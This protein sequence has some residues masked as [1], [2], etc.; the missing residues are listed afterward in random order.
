MQRPDNPHVALILGKLVA[1]GEG[2]PTNEQKCQLLADLHARAP[3]AVQMVHME[4]LRRSDRMG[5]GL[6]EAKTCIGQ[7][8][9]KIEELLGKAWYPGLFMGYLGEPAERC[10][11]VFQGNTW[12]VVGVFD[13]VPVDSLTKGCEVLLNRELTAIVGLSPRPCRPT[14]QIATV[15]E[16]TA[17]GNLII[18]SQE[19][20]VEVEM[21]ASLKDVPIKAGDRVRWDSSA[22]I[23]FERVEGSD[24]SQYLLGEVPNVPLDAVGGQEENMAKLL[25]V[26]S[27]VLVEPQKAA[28]YGLSGRSSVLLVGKPGCGKTLMVRT[29]VSEIARRAGR[30]A[31]FFAVKPSEWESCLVG[32]TEK[33]I[34]ALFT[35][36]RTST[37]DGSLAVLFLDEVD[38]VGRVRG[39]AQGHYSDK[40]LNALLAELD[41]FTG[42]EGVAVVATTN[43]KDLIDSALLQRLSDHELHVRP[44]DMK[45]AKAIFSIHLRPSL[46]FSPNGTMASATRLELIETAVARIYNPNS[47]YTELCRLKFRD[48]KTRM[49]SA[50]DFACGRLFEQICKAAKLSAYQREVRGGQRGLA[51]GDIEEAV[52]SAMERLATNVTIH[53]VRNQLPDLPTDVDVV[54]VEPIP[55]RVDRPHRY[56]IDPPSAA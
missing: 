22:C 10:A 49:V 31:R 14:G 4:L 29:A 36:L 13:K 25:G 56:L 42:R 1:T 40:A 3:E 21:A 37:Q 16:A 15:V 33:N 8:R 11:R 51:V 20:D 17:H 41:G 26:L 30:T 55:R 35:T 53:N 6:E 50:R 23:A 12:R 24:A 5:A 38:G 52:A 47:P 46:P 7:L 45:G 32:N 48:G 9:D 43:R 28:E 54:A 2:A 19:M 39:H 18:K 44:P 27:A 34:R